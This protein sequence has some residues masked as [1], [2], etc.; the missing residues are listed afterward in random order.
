MNLKQ[1]LEEI[2]QDDPGCKDRSTQRRLIIKRQERISNIICRVIGQSQELDGI[3]ELTP[4]EDTR[5]QPSI[6]IEG[7]SADE[8]SMSLESKAKDGKTKAKVIMLD[9]GEFVRNEILTQTQDSLETSEGLETD[10][11]CKSVKQETRRVGKK[12]TGLT[13]EITASAES[14]QM[15]NPLTLNSPVK[16]SRPNTPRKLLTKQR[17][18]EAQQMPVNLPEIPLDAVKFSESTYHLENQLQ[19]RLAEDPLLDGILK[20]KDLDNEEKLDLREKE[21]GQLKNIVNYLLSN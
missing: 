8:H 20:I 5:L 19:R 7:A 4:S 10:E 11:S 6:P 2:K 1:Q 12:E 16:G 3:D 15:K 13:V 9:T 14:L 21:K 17:R 18:A